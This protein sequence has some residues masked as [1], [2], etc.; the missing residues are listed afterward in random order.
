MMFFGI[1]GR[2][3]GYG[4][5]PARSWELTEEERAAVESECKRCGARAGYWCLAGGMPASVICP[6]GTLSKSAAVTFT[7]SRERSSWLEP[8]ICRSKIFLAVSA[9]DK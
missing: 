7:S 5:L 2:Q 3:N 6:C 1:F 4:S 8:F 9:V